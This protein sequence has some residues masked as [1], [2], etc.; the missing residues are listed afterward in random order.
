MNSSC[1]EGEVKL[2]VERDE[3]VEEEQRN[4]IE[5]V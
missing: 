5:L 3:P 4:E 1:R 2:N